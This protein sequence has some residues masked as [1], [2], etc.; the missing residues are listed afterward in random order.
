ME[1]STR[2]IVTDYV[3]P[4]LEW[5]KEECKKLGIEFTALQMKN[6]SPKELIEVCGGADILLV[7]MAKMT[8][9][10]MKGLSNVKVVIRHGIGYDNIDLATATEAGIICANQPKA[11]NED[12]AEH[13]ITLMFAA[14]RKIKKQ[15][16]LMAPS[17][18]A[19]KWDYAGLGN[20]Y[21]IAGKTVGI[22]GCGNIGS[23][24]VKKLFG[25]KVRCLV[26][27]P[28]LSADRAKELGVVL[29]DMD[30]LLKESDMVTVHVP[31]TDETRGMFNK[32]LFR[33]M[34]PTAVFVNTS[35]G[36]L[37]NAEDLAAALRE[38]VI[39]GAGIDVYVKEP[40]EKDHP[41]LGMDN[42]VLTP[43]YAWSSFE[44]AREIREMI[45][46]DVRRFLNNQPP[47]GVVN[48]KVLRSPNLRLKQAAR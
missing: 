7:N 46:D 33:K 26:Y 4:D 35:R 20:L 39:A 19:G 25:F 48:P 38:G 40:P 5:E 28:Y 12:V 31:V 27:D 24:I 21:R 37:V 13:A 29:T 14:F 41:L 34:K 3:E 1:R 44:G 10:V 8:A 16:S 36:A 23:H 2:F 9:E 17:I 11:S 47:L 6:A 42:A 15:E 45:M 43:H 22:V 18:E 32:D 30:T